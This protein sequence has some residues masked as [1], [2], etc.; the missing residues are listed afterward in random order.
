M[1]RFSLALILSFTL[2][3]CASA[4][5]RPPAVAPPQV[6]NGAT[7]V[8]RSAEYQAAVLQTYRYATAHVEAASAGRRAGSWVVIL[9][10]DETVLNNV[11]YQLERE[12]AGLPYTAESWNAWVRRREATPVPG[13]AAFLSRVK[14]LGGVVAIITNRLE[15]E[16]E[17]TRAVFRA[18][19][20]V[21][22]AMLCRLDGSPSDK[23]P[24]FTAVAGGQFPGASGPLDVVA[25]V[26]DNI[27]D[28]PSL[29][30]AI[31]QQGESAF[32]DFG[33]KFFV[34][35]NPM[36]GSWQR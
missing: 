17:D 24:R 33:V 26:G 16:C 10:A 36:Y 27:L 23:N 12:R 25:V 9:D 1:R 20:L 5:P 30:Q 13:A 2:T 35:P 18:H 29:S 22:D 4:P 7:W 28:F 19:Q 31:R 6:T 14:S 21:F 11:V 8:D 3:A 34:L 32:A 15:S